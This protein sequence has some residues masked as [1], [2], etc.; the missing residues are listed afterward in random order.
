MLLVRLVFGIAML[1]M[2]RRLFWLFLGGIGFVFAFDLAERTIHGQPHSVLLA[3]ALFAGVIGAV[4]AIFLQKLAV[5]VAGF[6]AGGYLFMGL[7]HELGMRT[8]N[9]HWLFFLLGGIAGAVLMS[10]LFGWTL[11]ILS[12]VIGS[13]LV[14]QSLHFGPQTARLLFVFLLALGIAVQYGLL[15]RRPRPRRMER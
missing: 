5:V 11:I 9:Y 12:S 15:E 10:A 4:L 2:G 1:T 13:A 14:V 8:G 3:V 7:L 6:F